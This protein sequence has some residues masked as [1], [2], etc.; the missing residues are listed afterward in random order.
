MN[1]AQSARLVRMQERY[2]TG[3]MPWDAELP[4]PEV[5]A[6]VDRLAPGRL[7]DLGCG[8][9]RASL[10]LAE[11]GWQADGVDFVPEAI[12]MAQRRVADAGLEQRVRLHV[13][14]VTDLGFLDPPYDLAI[15]VGCFHGMEPDEQQRYAAEVA[16][17]LRPGALFLLFAYLHQHGSELLPVS[18]AAGSVEA[19]FDADFTVAGVVYGETSVEGHWASAWYELIRRG[20]VRGA[21]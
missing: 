9:A 6:L 18:T 19:C 11:H 8:T 2:R 15:D 12:A 14:S 16:R 10:F 5:I 20:E 4:P 7:I 13:A 1:E 3:D 17:M 21:E